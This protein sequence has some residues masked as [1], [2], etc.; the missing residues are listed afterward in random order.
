MCPFLQAFRHPLNEFLASLQDKG[1][2][3]QQMPYQARLDLKVLAAAILQSSSS[4]PIPFLPTGPTL[5]AL[6]FVSDAAGAHF[7]LT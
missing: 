1:D 2:T 7:F 6:V 3:A 4:L 5:G